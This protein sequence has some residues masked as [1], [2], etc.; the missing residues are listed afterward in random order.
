MNKIQ[1][2]EFVEIIVPQS[3]TATK[4]YFND[5]PQLRFV[6]L[7]NMSSYTPNVMTN[8]ILSGNPLLS[9]ANLKNTYLVL[10]AND[11]ESINRIPVL[12]LNRIASNSTSA[13]PYAFQLNAFAGQK[14]TWSKSYIQTPVAYSS[15]SASNYSVCF[16]VYY[17]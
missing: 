3:S 5:Q 6:S 13:D 1:N 15:I 16:G 14:V 7:L 11:K 2:Y 17:A 4:F 8:S 10:Y 9:I 12:E